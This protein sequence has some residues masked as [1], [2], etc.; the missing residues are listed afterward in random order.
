MSHCLLESLPGRGRHVRGVVQDLE[1]EQPA[2]QLQ[3][4]GEAVKRLARDIA[5]ME[6]RTQAHQYLSV[7]REAP[8][9]LPAALLAAA[10]KRDWADRSVSRRTH[11]LVTTDNATPISKTAAAI[12]A[13]FRRVI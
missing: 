1:A 12:S 13:G 8:F 7:G 5:A 10:S 4:V 6:Q 2:L 3:G 11:W 9:D